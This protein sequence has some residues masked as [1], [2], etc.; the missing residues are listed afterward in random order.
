MFTILD[1]I[2]WPGSPDRANE[3]ACG[4]SKS[5]AWVID[6]SIFP[7]TPAIM[8][9]TSAVVCRKPRTGMSRTS[10]ASYKAGSVELRET[11]AS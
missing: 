9:E 3:D 6:T 10:R 8:H 11:K 5:W 4:A 7:G 1:Q 2:S